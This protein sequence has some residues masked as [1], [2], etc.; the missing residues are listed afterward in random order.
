MIKR[1]KLYEQIADLIQEDIARGAVRVGDQLPSERE[2][3][4]KYGVGRAAVREALFALAKMGLIAISSGE[5][6]RVIEPTP[7]V[8]VQELSGAARLFLASENGIQRFQEARLVF[9]VALARRAAEIATAEDIAAIEAARVANRDAV[10][11]LQFEK[12]DVIF[13]R[14]IARVGGNPIF[15]AISDAVTEWLIEQ[16]RGTARIPQAKQL[17]IEW[18]TRISDAIARHDA[19]AAADAMAGHLD[20]VNRFYWQLRDAERQDQEREQAKLGA[21]LTQG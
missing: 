3:M 2:I 20:Q 13:H 11:R 9:E 7:A 19:A 1:R 5:R 15:P 21:L 10:D 14:A 4:A 18:H 12:T 17:A 16:R 6:A 8:L